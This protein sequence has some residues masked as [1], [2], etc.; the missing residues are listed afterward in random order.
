MALF[1]LEI[2]AV[3]ITIVQTRPHPQST[4][5]S[6][7]V[8]AVI[9]LLLDRSK[10]CLDYCWGWAGLNKVDFKFELMA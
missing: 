2:A 3:T 6:R 9:V 8:T 1:M 4:F 5:R 10:A 7:S